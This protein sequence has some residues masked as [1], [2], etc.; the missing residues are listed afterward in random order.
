MGARGPGLRV[1][2][3]EERSGLAL[4]RA[5]PPRLRAQAVLFEDACGPDV[6]ETRVQPGD[7]LHLCGFARDNRFVPYEGVPV[8]KFD[9]ELRE[10]V[11][12]VVDAY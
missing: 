9:D 2:T 7:D 1:L 6:P 8:A 11:M 10:L 3:V 12:E 5:L 4:V